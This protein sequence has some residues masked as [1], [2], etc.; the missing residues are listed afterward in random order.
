MLTE[1]K[2]FTLS[3]SAKVFS[4]ALCLSLSSNSVWVEEIA[5]IRYAKNDQSFS[6]LKPAKQVLF[7]AF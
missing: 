3:K 2:W 1:I 4:S 5:N 7:W 6:P